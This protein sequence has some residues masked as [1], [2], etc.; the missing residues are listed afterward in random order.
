MNNNSDQLTTVKQ[1]LLN[2]AESTIQVILINVSDKRD[3]S[4]VTIY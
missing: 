4:V 3:S 2:L 1:L